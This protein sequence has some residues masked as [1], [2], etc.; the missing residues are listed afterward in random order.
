MQI[1]IELSMHK[2]EL[3]MRTHVGNQIVVALE[4]FSKIFCRFYFKNGKKQITKA[5]N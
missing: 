3:A 1:T 5:S 4:D 2:K